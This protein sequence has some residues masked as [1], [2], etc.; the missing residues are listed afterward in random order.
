VHKLG[1]TITW[2]VLPGNNFQ[3]IP[4]EIFDFQQLEVLHLSRNS[5]SYVS[6]YKLAKLTRLKELELACNRLK[7]EKKK[8]FCSIF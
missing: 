2:L 3:E 7:G 5:I 4:D 8:N 1:K 6:P